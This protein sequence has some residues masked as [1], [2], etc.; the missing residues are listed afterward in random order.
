MKLHLRTDM[1]QHVVL[2][3]TD[4]GR[5]NL[6]I[7]SKGRPAKESFKEVE[8]SHLTALCVNEKAI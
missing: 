2:V 1:Q 3:D 6:A 7:H 4:Q 5:G 8:T